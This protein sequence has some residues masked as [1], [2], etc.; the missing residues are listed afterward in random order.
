MIV[1][2]LRKADLIRARAQMIEDKSVSGE[3]AG[4]DQSRTTPQC[5]RTG[6]EHLSRSGIAN[7]KGDATAATGI[8]I[9][10]NWNERA[11]DRFAIAATKRYRELENIVIMLTS[12]PN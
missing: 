7:E 11:T 1:A 9:V 12:D 10:L 4:S 8:C 5:R 3:R 6:C 2:I